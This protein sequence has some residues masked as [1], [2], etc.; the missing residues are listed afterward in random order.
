MN[1]GRLLLP[2]THGVD[3]QALEFAISFAHSRHATLI[4]L[5]LIPV[6]QRQRTRGIRLEMFQQAQDFLEAASFKATKYDVAIERV[7]VVT[8]NVVEQ[9][10]QVLSSQKCDG[11]LLFMREAKGVLLQ[12]Q[13][14]KALIEQRGPPCYLIHL[15]SARRTQQAHNIIQRFWKWLSRRS[16]AFK[17]TSHESQIQEPMYLID[18][19]N[20][21][22]VTQYEKEPIG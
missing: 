16:I 4:P 10:G 8:H 14:I 3:M 22:T 18:M 6:V 19:D 13:E 21:K 11:M 12:E 15:P 5:V 2:F 17:R 20:D 7:E 9:I 1:M